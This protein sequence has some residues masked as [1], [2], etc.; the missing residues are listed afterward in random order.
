MVVK[1]LLTPFWTYCISV[2]HVLIS[3]LGMTH[4]FPN[5][6]IIII[7]S[8]TLD[9]VLGLWHFA[10]S[11]V[12]TAVWKHRYYFPYEWRWKCWAGPSQ[13]LSDVWYI[14]RTIYSIKNNT[15]PP[16]T[17]IIHTSKMKLNRSQNT[18]WDIRWRILHNDKID[19]QHI[20]TYPLTTK[21][22]WID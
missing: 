13:Q 14:I 1:Y 7:F 4:I 5:Y 18:M 2:V 6:T 9:S 8:T 3:L 20:E 11:A 16:Y 19:H 15:M 17:I 22:N 12:I 10:A 21:I